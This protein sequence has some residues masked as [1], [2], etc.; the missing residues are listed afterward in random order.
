MSVSTPYYTTAGRLAVEI[1]ADRPALG[2]TVWAGRGLGCFHQGER[3]QVSDTTELRDAW[4]VTS[5]LTNWPHDLLARV[6]DAGIHLRLEQLDLGLC[7]VNGS[8]GGNCGIRCGVR[9]V[10]LSLFGGDRTLLRERR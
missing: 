7:V 10:R 1:H 6:Q 5:G 2:E 4:M 3:V 9:R 8:G